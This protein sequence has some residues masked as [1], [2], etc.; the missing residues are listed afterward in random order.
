M[1]TSH[2]N[3]EAPGSHCTWAVL[4]LN[5]LLALSAERGATDDVQLGQ[6]GRC[7]PGRSDDKMSLGT[8]REVGDTSVG[9]RTDL[10]RVRLHLGRKLHRF[11]ASARLQGQDRIVA[12]R[13]IVDEQP[14]RLPCAVRDELWRVA[15][16]DGFD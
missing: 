5:P 1:D 2:L 7:A 14:P 10:V 13:E 16:G 3:P 8:A 9:E 6:I 15:L 11:K 4:P 12:A